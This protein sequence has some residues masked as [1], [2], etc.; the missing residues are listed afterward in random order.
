MSIEDSLTL[1]KPKTVFVDKAGNI[2]KNQQ[3]EVYYR[4]EKISDQIQIRMMYIPEG[5]FWMGTPDEEIERLN[6]KYNSEV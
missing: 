1:W 5:E 2:T 3:Y 6:K 4:D